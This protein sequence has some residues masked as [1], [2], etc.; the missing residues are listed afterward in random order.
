MRPWKYLM[1]AAGLLGAIAIFMPIITIKKSFFEQSYSARDLLISGENTRGVLSGGLPKF[2][3][4][5]LPKSVQSLRSDVADVLTAMRALSCVF[6]PS[7]LL[8]ALGVIAAFRRCGRVVG[9]IAVL[10]SL[11]SIAGWYALRW[12]LREYG[13]DVVSLKLAAAAT[14]PLVVGLLGIVGGIG[15]IVQPEVAAPQ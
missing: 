7:L 8:F 14:I 10:L 2:A 15:S 11:C 9:C 4:S 6:V 1:I 12:G 3:E 5:R 13:T